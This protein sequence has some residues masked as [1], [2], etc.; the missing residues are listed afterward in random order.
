MQKDAKMTLRYSHENPDIKRVYSEFY[1]NPLSQAAEEMLHTSY[2]SRA[3]D[4]GP[5]GMV[6]K[7]NLQKPAWEQDKEN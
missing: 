3:E 1:G 4:L 6:L 2:Y 7:M 5:E